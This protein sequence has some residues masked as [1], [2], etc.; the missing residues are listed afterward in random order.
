VI[1][2]K[3]SL[4]QKT[5][6]EMVFNNSMKDT[7]TQPEVEK[8]KTA[9]TPEDG[10]SPEVKSESKTSSISETKLESESKSETKSESK[11]GSGS[12]KTGDDTPISSYAA[13][14]AAAV[15][16]LVLAGEVRRRH[17]NSHK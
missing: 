1:T 17:R 8:E 6:E 9:A 3:I 5:V 2:S 13:L 14:L 16:L 7:S 4:N 12:V 15:V 10:S 11:A